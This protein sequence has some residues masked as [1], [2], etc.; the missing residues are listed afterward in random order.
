MRIWLFSDARNF[1]RF[2]R[3]GVEGVSDEVTAERRCIRQVVSKRFRQG[4]ATGCAGEA[5]CVAASC[6]RLPRRA[7]WTASL[8]AIGPNARGNACEGDLWRSIDGIERAQPCGSRVL[9]DEGPPARWVLQQY[10]RLRSGARQIESSLCGPVGG[11][12]ASRPA[13][14]RRHSDARELPRGGAVRRRG[15]G[16]TREPRAAP[17]SR[18]RAP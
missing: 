4:N 9:I 14:A 16:P 13:P 12:K 6:R 7:G 15:F 5:S 8:T 3:N 17:N 2:F 18:L 10:Q 1:V 11:R